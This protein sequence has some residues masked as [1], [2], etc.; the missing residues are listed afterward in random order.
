MHP[1]RNS[2]S[3]PSALEHTSESIQPVGKDTEKVLQQ[4]LRLLLVE[5]YVGGSRSLLWAQTEH[6]PQ[7]EKD[8]RHRVTDI[9]WK[10]ACSKSSWA[11]RGAARAPGVSAIH[12]A[13]P[14]NSERKDRKPQSPGTHTL[15]HTPASGLSL[16]TG[17]SQ[18][19]LSPS[20]FNNALL[21]SLAEQYE[22]SRSHRNDCKAA[23][24]G[25]SGTPSDPSTLHTRTVFS[26]ALPS[27]V[28][29]STFHNKRSLTWLLRLQRLDTLIAPKFQLSE[30]KMRSFW[31]TESHFWKKH[32]P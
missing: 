32:L 19:C 6:T 8:L 17:T 27:I 30:T 20:F 29:S 1:L 24:M 21:L 31:K 2:G 14:G 26:P 11:L 18:H 12:T 3:Q 13:G 28:E 23:T 22:L 10:A 5:S 7:S 16:A 15:L 25:N 4:L 9:Q